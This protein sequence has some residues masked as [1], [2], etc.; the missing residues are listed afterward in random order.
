MKWPE[1]T[2]GSIV[3]IC[4][5]ALVAFSDAFISCEGRDAEGCKW[6]CT[7]PGKKIQGKK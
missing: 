1:A 3:I 6:G 2:V 7:T 4:L 5:V